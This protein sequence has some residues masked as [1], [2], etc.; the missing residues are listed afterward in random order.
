MLHRALAM[1]TSLLS[2]S[3]RRLYPQF[4][5]PG[6]DA[7]NAEWLGHHETG[8]SYVLDPLVPH[9]WQEASAMCWRHCTHTAILS[10]WTIFLVPAWEFLARYLH[11]RRIQVLFLCHN[12]VDHEASLWKE[13][14]SRR[15]LR[16]GDLFFATNRRDSDLLRQ[17]MP[18]ARISFYPH[19]LYRQFPPAVHI[20]PRKARLELLF[21]GFVRHY[22]GLD[23]LAQAMTLL[24]N[25]D[26][27]LT[28]AG[29]WWS[30]MPLCRQ[31]QNGELKHKVSIVARYVTAAETA[32]L[33]ARADVVV[34]PYRS[35]SGSGVIAQA[36]HYRKPVIATTVGGLPDTVREGVSGFLV[37]PENPQVLAAAIRRFLQ[38]PP[39]DFGQG[40]AA[41]AATM[42]W[43]GLAGHLL[44][45][46]TGEKQ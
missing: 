41:L 6:R 5:Y 22:K 18:Q 27:H 35:G 21:Y 31:L 13:W 43:E 9:T 39:P 15:L 32:E 33:F 40:I 28:I 42:T 7:R 45:F 17:M 44:H 12:V 3:F 30:E 10:W 1:E 20:L 8:V 29:E 19:P 26:V 36:Y 24:R 25:E 38:T 16:Q 2:L 34:L 46:I 14:L 37:E 11:R 4:L 23:V